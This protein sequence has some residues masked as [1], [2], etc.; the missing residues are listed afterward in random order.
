MTILSGTTADESFQPPAGDRPAAVQAGIDSAAASSGTETLVADFSAATESVAMTSLLRQADGWAGTFGDSGSHRVTFSGIARFELT[1]GGGGDILTGGDGDDVLVGGA[2]NDTIEGGT[3]SDSLSGGDG[4]DIL[5]VTGAGSVTVAG[6]AGTDTLIIDY[7]SIA[8][9]VTRSLGKL[10]DGWSGTFTDLGDNKVEFSSVERFIFTGGAGSDSFMASDGDDVL[11]G[12]GSADVFYALSGN[13]VL[14]GEAGDDQLD[15]GQGDDRMMGGA[16]GDFYIVDSLGDVVTEL[17][18]EGHDYVRTALAAYALPANVEE[19]IGTNAGG[20]TL[21]GN[22]LD[23]IVTGDAGADIFR[24]EDGGADTVDGGDGDDLLVFGGAFGDDRVTGGA[25]HDT[26]VLQGVYDGLRLDASALAGVESL[27]LLG[28]DDASYGAPTPGP[29][30]YDIVAPSLSV[31]YGTLWVGAGGLAGDETLR[32]DGSRI[33]S[34]NL[35]VWSGDGNDLLIGG[36]GRNEL[37]G[38]DGDDRLEGGPGID[39][40]DGGT[41]DDVLVDSG[42]S[43]GFH[44]GDGD[45]VLVARHQAGS[46]GGPVFLDGGDGDDDATLD[47]APRSLATVDMGAGNDIVRMVGG[48]LGADLTLGAGSDTIAVGAGAG[49]F[50]VTD[51]TVGTGGD[52]FDWTAV[53]ASGLIGYSP[54]DNLFAAGYAKL[55]QNGADTYVILDRDGAA[56]NYH[57]EPVAVLE[58]VELAS[59]AAF[60]LG[61]APQADGTADDDWVEG[62][63]GNDVLDLSGGGNDIVLG[64]GGNDYLF[65][66]GAFAGDRVDGGTGN[67]TLA[68]LG[69]YEVIL[70]EGTLSGIEVLALLS[71][72]AAGGS[73]HVNYS[74]TMD[75]GNVAAGQV[76]TVYA[77]GLL[78]DESLVFNGLAESDGAYLINGGA[79]ADSLV[80]GQRNDSIVGGGGADH[81]F[82]MGGNDWLEGGAGA[83]QLRGGFGSDLFV[84]KSASDSAPGASDHIVD[85]EDQTDLINLVGIDANTQVGGDQAFSFIGQ[86]AFS[87]T[88]GEL[89][90]EGSGSN[91]FVEGDI[92]G[93]GLADLIIQVDNFRGYALQATN[94][95]L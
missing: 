62:G 4:D 70:G 30:R 88:A 54:S 9:G 31:G 6:G 41:G 22:A 25:G 78:A 84:Y 23:N 91:W 20:M 56:T 87:H 35:T 63:G 92:D 15:G 28:H 52:R 85:F 3:G 68:L 37:H 48:V 19:L 18:D 90:I 83:D 12:G 81:L 77:G 2:G 39:I 49:L 82:G 10:G 17:A 38:A 58:H 26:V 50:W 86:N 76:L 32:F 72:T 29:N 65:F 36:A 7:S 89:R 1:G 24:L 5:R 47:L 13:D 64:G 27:I 55:A 57:D 40:L 44:G 45:D 21:R 79:A 66:G 8:G 95:M 42:G 69:R 43:V 74:L 51:F 75:D 67:D 46:A 93:D 60:N 73:S 59:L 71:G 16:G 14:N 61:F 80:G 53:L 11:S 94:F 33:V 34:G